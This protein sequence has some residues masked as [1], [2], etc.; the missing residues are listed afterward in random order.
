MS[1]TD[2]AL[3]QEIHADFAFCRISGRKYGVL[4]IIDTATTYYET[5]FVASRTEEFMVRSIEY[6]LLLQHGAPQSFS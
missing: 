4:H 3:D 2:A 5:T 6:V 1:R